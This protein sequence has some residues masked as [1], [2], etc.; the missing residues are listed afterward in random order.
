MEAAS[1]KRTC[2]SRRAP[3]SGDH[4]QHHELHERYGSRRLWRELRRRGIDCGRHRMDRL[5]REQGLCTRR[6]RR[7]MRARAAYQRTPAAPR[8]CTWP[9]ATDAPD[10]LWIGDMTVLPTRE[11]P[12]YFAALVDACS[13]RVIGW[14]MDDHQ[15][16]DLTERAL[17]MALQQRHPKPGLLLHHDRGSQYTGARGGSRWWTWTAHASTSCCCRRSSRP[18]PAKAETKPD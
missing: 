13:R 12:L 1:A 18:P 6:R 14:A 3:C 9:F 5:R 11:G 7:F 16:L 2:A 10:R 15:R 17:E 4:G 8:L